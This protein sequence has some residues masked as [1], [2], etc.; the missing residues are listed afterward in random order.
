MRKRHALF[1]CTGNSCRRELPSLFYLAQ[2][3]FTSVSMIRPNWRRMR[4]TKSRPWSAIAVCEIRFATSSRTTSFDDC[5][6][7]KTNEPDTS[8]RSATRLAVDAKSQD[9]GRRLR[10]SIW[11]GRA[12]ESSSA[13]QSQR[14]GRYD[15]R[16]DRR[17]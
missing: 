4:Q 11:R 1:L 13:P 5:R 12:G 6:L 9:V 14:L 10:G 2:N 15:R 16:S 3:W 8:L 7:Q 17:L